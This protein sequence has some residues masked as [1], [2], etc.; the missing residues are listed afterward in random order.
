MA[1]WLIRAGKHG[2][3]EQKFLTE[4]RVYLTWDGLAKDLTT[5]SSRAALSAELR[6]LFPTAPPGRLRNWVAQIWPF[7]HLIQKGDLV[8]LPLK[9]QPAHSDW[10]GFRGLPF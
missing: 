5:F 6:K 4:N 1:I 9:T 7:G 10:R 2:E 3:Y 8:I